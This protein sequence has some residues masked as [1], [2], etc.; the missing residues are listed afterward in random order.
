MKTATV[1][2]DLFFF[3]G[4]ISIHAV[5]KTATVCMAVNFVKINYFNPCSHEDCNPACVV[6]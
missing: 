1:S 4:T 3:K 6:I 5:M 2:Y